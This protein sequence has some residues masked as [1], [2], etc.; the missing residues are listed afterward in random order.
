MENPKVFE[1]QLMKD[2]ATAKE[3]VAK[4]AEARGI[5]KIQDKDFGFEPKALRIK[6]KL[7]GQKELADL[8]RQIQDTVKELTFQV[9][10]VE[11]GKQAL[12]RRELTNRFN[13][14]RDLVLRS[15]LELEKRLTSEKLDLEDRQ[16]LIQGFM[17]AASGIGFLGATK[18]RS[19]FTSGN[20]ASRE[21]SNVNMEPISLTAEG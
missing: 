14:S 11:G 20:V 5:R 4:G 10:Q 12:F 15:G 7:V 17:S 13:A 19:L 6:G 1:E 2:V 9:G 18:G 3:R 8:N 16:A 21:G